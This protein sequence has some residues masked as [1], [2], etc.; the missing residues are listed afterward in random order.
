MTACGNAPF[1]DYS[2]LANLNQNK[3]LSPPSGFAARYTGVGSV[4]LTWTPPSDYI[5]HPENYLGFFILKNYQK[6]GSND[7]PVPPVMFNDPKAPYAVAVYV[8]RNSQMGETTNLTNTFEQNFSD[9]NTSPGS[10]YAYS[11]FLIA[12]DLTYSSAASVVANLPS[13]NGSTLLINETFTGAKVSGSTITSGLNSLGLSFQTNN[14]T[15]TSLSVGA[16]TGQQAI[17]IGGSTTS[18]TTLTSDL[19]PSGNLSLEPNTLYSFTYWTRSTYNPAIY[20]GNNEDGAANA[21]SGILSLEMSNANVLQQY[22][23]LHQE[24]LS[25]ASEAACTTDLTK[26]IAAYDFAGNPPT[27]QYF[28]Q[29]YNSVWTQNGVVFLT[30]GLSSELPSTPKN[31]YGPNGGDSTQMFIQPENNSLVNVQVT[32]NLGKIDPSAW[33]TDV[34]SISAEIGQITLAKGVYFGQTTYEKML[35]QTP[36]NFLLNPNTS[37]DITTKAVSGPNTLPG[38]P[39][40]D[41][42][43]P[44]AANWMINGG[45]FGYTPNL[46]TYYALLKPTCD[47]T[48]TLSQSIWYMSLIAG[49][50]YDISFDVLVGPSNLQELICKSTPNYF[51]TDPLAISALQID[52]LNSS[53][54]PVGTFTTIAFNSN[55]AQSTGFD[56]GQ[57]ASLTASEAVT[58][59]PGAT[60]NA[61]CQTS[62]AILPGWVKV[63]Y[64]YL[65]P[66]QAE[67]Y[68]N[69]SPTLQ[70]TMAK[71]VSGLAPY[72]SIRNIS[73]APQPADIAAGKIA[74]QGFDMP[75]PIP[76]VPSSI[77][78]VTT[79][80]KYV[81]TWDFTAMNAKDPI[82]SQL[83]SLNGAKIGPSSPNPVGGMLVL[84]QKD[85]DPANLSVVTD[86]NSQNVLCITCNSGSI[87]PFSGSVLVTSE[88]FTSGVFDCY[89]KVANVMKNGV[90]IPSNQPVGFTFADWV[91]SYQDYNGTYD[92]RSLMSFGQDRNPEIDIE[93]GGNCPKGLENTDYSYTIGRLNCW[94]GVLGG[95]GGNLEMH[96][97]MPN[98][99]NLSVAPPTNNGYHKLTIVLNAGADMLSPTSNTQ[100]RSPGYIKWYMNDIF[101]GGGWLGANY[102]TDNIPHTGMRFT[103]G[104]WY[105]TSGWAGDLFEADGKTYIWD[106]ADFYMTKMQYTPLYNNGATDQTNYMIP[107]AAG[108]PTVN[109]FPN[110]DFYLPEFNPYNHCDPSGT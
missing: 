16:F 27:Y 101:W 103:V 26:R 33:G 55:P 99:F 52:V 97:M 41:L 69:L 6:Y 74:V 58:Q 1:G 60:I 49:Q 35:A 42:S 106:T 102:G 70:F 30:G 82:L 10:S 37:F 57:G 39:Q 72:W 96:T 93:I 65:V 36:L 59:T 104:P 38:Y 32:F 5:S 44:A 76:T 31:L 109:P 15:L 46:K 88:Y 68:K 83:V 40:G 86:S 107:P 81:Q 67:A 14:P 12:S 80:P 75:V 79:N 8:G 28:G 17:M 77:S 54:N 56:E 71:A 108:S 73:I 110:R 24:D 62:N 7:A 89:V 87:E 19:I 98:D 84:N 45:N 18:S 95:T 64:T 63:T 78:G 23:L 3:N 48:A 47:A 43:C 11:L 4:S 20:K 100:T 105:P 22:Q 51:C 61:A 66:P 9:V 21:L 13:D 2:T 34:S 29:A 50:S 53:K 25:T 85:S 90:Q 91:Y 92:N 94:G